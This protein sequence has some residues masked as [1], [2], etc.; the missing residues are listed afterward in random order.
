VTLFYWGQTETVKGNGQWAVVGKA[1]GKD[2][3]RCQPSRKLWN[4]LKDTRHTGSDAGLVFCI[5]WLTHQLV[6]WLTSINFINSI[7][8]V[9]LLLLFEKV[10]LQS[11]VNMLTC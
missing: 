3:N 11:L 5:N 6:N 8:P 2:E 4:S 1:E 7:N 10:S 9:N